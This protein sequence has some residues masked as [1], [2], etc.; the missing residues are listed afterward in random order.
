MLA[1][2]ERE[3][4][5]QPGEPLLGGIAHAG[6]QDRQHPQP[7][8][9]SV[10]NHHQLLQRFVPVCRWDGRNQCGKPPV[11]GEKGR[12]GHHQGEVATPLLQDESGSQR[13]LRPG[14]VAD[15]DHGVA[16][17]SGEHPRG[18]DP[19]DRGDVGTGALPAPA[20]KTGHVQH[21]TGRPLSGQRV[22]HDP[23]VAGEPETGEQHDKGSRPALRRP[24]ADDPGVNPALGEG[25][26]RLLDGKLS[27]IGHETH[28]RAGGGT[29][30]AGKTGGYWTS[31]PHLDHRRSTMDDPRTAPSLEEPTAPHEPFPPKPDQAAPKSSRPPASPPAHR[32]RRGASR[33][34]SS[35]PPRD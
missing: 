10:R 35:R 23:G 9:G 17:T 8:A 22:R 3:R 1:C 16:G 19:P 12:A 15:Q 7:P 2:G 32:T 28:H 6:A 4:H 29:R 5:T 25:G 21:H 27:V 11:P 31:T 24:R 26:P 33:A 20:A 18:G 14:R 13:G 34:C 30:F